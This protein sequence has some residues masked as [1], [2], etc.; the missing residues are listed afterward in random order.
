MDHCE[1]IEKNDK[2]YPFFVAKLI[3]KSKFQDIVLCIIMFP[4]DVESLVNART[5]HFLAGW[6]YYYISNALHDYNTVHKTAS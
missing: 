5:V 2:S 3:P 1:K 6:G 4:I